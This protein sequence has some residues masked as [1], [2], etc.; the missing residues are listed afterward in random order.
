MATPPQEPAWAEVDPGLDARK[1]EW[2]R[3]PATRFP[4]GSYINAV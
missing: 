4:M 1:Q 3:Q 2:I